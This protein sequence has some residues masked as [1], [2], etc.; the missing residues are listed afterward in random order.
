[1]MP[2]V[3]EFFGQWIR[4]IGGEQDQNHW[5][6][7][8]ILMGWPPL[9]VLLE[10]APSTTTVAGLRCFIRSV[11]FW[12]QTCWAGVNLEMKSSNVCETLHSMYAKSQL[13]SSDR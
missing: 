9:A 3:R 6:D 13:L 8:K 1:V 5:N 4:C 7:G 12:N 2:L 10:S 11:A